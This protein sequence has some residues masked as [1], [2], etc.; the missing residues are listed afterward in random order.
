[1]THTLISILSIFSGFFGAHFFALVKPKF[2]LG[3]TGNS[4]V[5]IFGSILLI[6]SFGRLGF[7]PFAIMETGNVNWLLF[8]INLMVSFLGGILFLMLTQWVVKKMNKA[9]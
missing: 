8:T 6:K 4:I 7:N 1:M 3:F 5:G 9:R 2:S